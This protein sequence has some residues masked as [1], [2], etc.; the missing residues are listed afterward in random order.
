MEF[1]QLDGWNF[2]IRRRIVEPI[3]VLVVLYF[4]AA[5][6]AKHFD[7]RVLAPCQ[8]ARRLT[9]R[10]D[11]IIL[12]RKSNFYQSKGGYDH[13]S[14]SYFHTMD[15]IG[16]E[17]LHSSIVKNQRLK[18]QITH[19]FVLLNF[20]KRLPFK[21]RH[22]FVNE[23]CSFY[24]QCTIIILRQNALS[25]DKWD[26][27]VTTWRQLDDWQTLCVKINKIVPFLFKG[28]SANGQP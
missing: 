8:E 12:R 7:D 28:Q 25:K 3:W 23:L 26:R 1:L 13:L 20:F 10:S 27:L 4:I 21:V 9:V 17:S 18:S 24:H 6:T 15:Q 5:L 11:T 14:S 2:F 16:H 19:N 22:N